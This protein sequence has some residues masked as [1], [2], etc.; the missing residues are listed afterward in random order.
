M[1][2][3]KVLSIRQPHIE[4][5]FAGDKKVENRGGLYPWKYRGRLYLHASGKHLTLPT[6]LILGHVDLVECVEYEVLHDLAIATRDARKF[7]KQP[8]RFRD[9]V[10]KL[11]A[12]NPAVWDRLQEW[13]RT[14]RD[15]QVRR[16]S[17]P[18]CY[19][20]ENPVR[21]PQPIPAKGMLG[22]WSFEIL[23]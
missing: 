15:C 12:E 11:K 22:I 4:A 19:L 18:W 13:K 5:I 1:T 17:G 7:H 6:G 9:T 3:A 14:D 8:K 16:I 21:L 23:E 10:E 2:I 20:L